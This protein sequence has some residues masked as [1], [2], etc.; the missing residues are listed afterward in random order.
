MANLKIREVHLLLI[1]SCMQLWLS[2]S[3]CSIFT[4]G[5]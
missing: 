1:S 2:A 3:L 5:W 4:K